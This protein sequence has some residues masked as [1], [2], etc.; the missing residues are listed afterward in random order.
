MK[1][2]IV[3]V[4]VMVLLSASGLWPN[5]QLNEELIL[6]AEAGDVGLVENLLERGA[7]IDAHNDWGV[8]ALMAASGSGEAAVV[9]LLLERGADIDA[10]DRYGKTALE[11]AYDQGHREVINVLRTA[12]LG[13]NGEL[14]QALLAAASL[15]DVELVKWFLDRGADIE[16]RLDEES[17]PGIFLASQPTSL[18]V[19]SRMDHPEVVKLL[20]DRGADV[21]AIFTY[22]LGDTVYSNSALGWA[23]GNGNSDLVEML[24]EYGATVNMVDEVGGAAFAGHKD[25]LKTLLDRGGN[26]TDALTAAARGGQLS[27]VEWLLQRGADVN[28]MD[29]EGYTALTS[30]L[31]PG[32]DQLVLLLLKRGAD[33]NIRDRQRIIIEDV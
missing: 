3:L 28:A 29:S 11:I 16:A 13:A 6:A 14:D 15:G 27:T 30:V 1:R 5:D 12:S 24:L 21:D 33:V 7:Q 9:E 20:L 26:I 4:V 8:T 2:P 10:R 19:A 31:L 22:F 23:S 18:I 32:H 25:I 17:T